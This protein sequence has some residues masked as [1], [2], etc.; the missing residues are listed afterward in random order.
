MV[1]VDVQ[2]QKRSK[3]CLYARRVAGATERSS[4]GKGVNGGV[5]REEY[6][7]GREEVNVGQGGFA[8]LNRRTVGVGLK[9]TRGLGARGVARVCDR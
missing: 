3:A 6:T 1:T 5:L 7:Q 8:G 4:R 2:R 9:D